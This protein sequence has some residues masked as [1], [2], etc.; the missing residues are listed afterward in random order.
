M[1]DSEVT[2]ILAIL[3]KPESATVGRRRR[4]KP[5]ASRVALNESSVL[6]AIPPAKRAGLG[7]DGDKRMP[8]PASITTPFFDGREQ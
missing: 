4:L 2:I 3:T 8:Y 7:P 6:V 5:L 1:I